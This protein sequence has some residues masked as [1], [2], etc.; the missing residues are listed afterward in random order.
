MKFP[1]NN[2]I[3]PYLSASSSWNAMFRQLLRWY[4]LKK[5]TINMKDGQMEGQEIANTLHLPC[6][7][8]ESLFS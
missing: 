4:Q 1:M 8:H 3:N 7:I 6:L 5:Y 2:T